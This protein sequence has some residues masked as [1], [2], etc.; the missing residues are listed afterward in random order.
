MTKAEVI[1]TLNNANYGSGIAEV[2]CDIS[3]NGQVIYPDESILV[4]LGGEACDDEK[5][6][7]GKHWTI[8][9]GVDDFD[10]GIVYGYQSARQCYC[11]HYVSNFK[12]VK[13]FKKVS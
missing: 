4:L 12:Q 6:R 7:M 9:N 11:K 10:I 1:C 5:L 8:C 3:C 2:I 13:P